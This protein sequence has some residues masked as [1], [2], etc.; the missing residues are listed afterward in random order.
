MDTEQ[1]EVKLLQ[2]LETL[3]K[4]SM[5]VH[6][7]QPESGPVLNTRIETLVQCLLDMNDAK[8]NTD[9]QVPFSLLEVVENGINPDQFTSDLV[10][11]LVDKNQKTKGRIESI[12]IL[13]DEIRTQLERNYPGLASEL[14]NITQ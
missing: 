10:Q 3:L 9:I 4:I 11:T 6:D 12:K 14:D 1:L 5:T 8:A 13:K 2:T 7:F